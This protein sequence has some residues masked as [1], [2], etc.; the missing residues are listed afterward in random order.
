MS[1][2]R[3]QEIYRDNRGSD[4]SAAPSFIVSMSSQLVIPGGLLSS[5]AHFR[6]TNREALCD[7][8]GARASVIKV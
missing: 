5:R 8:N 6:F 3:H 2:L 1:F 4:L 7:R